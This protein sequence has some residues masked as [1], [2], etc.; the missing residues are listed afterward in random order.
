MNIKKIVSA[1]KDSNLENAD[2]LITGIETL[3]H[4]LNNENKT[5]REAKEST[6]GK[7]KEFSGVDSDSLEDILST[8][9]NKQ[10]GE[11]SLSRK[12]EKLEAALA[13]IEQEKTALE[14]SNHEKTRNENIMKTLS[15]QGVRK[16]AIEGLTQMFGSM[17]KLDDDGEWLIGD[18][19]LETGIS[20]YVAK[21][22][23]FVDSQQKAGS[24]TSEPKGNGK[25]T[26][27][28]S[29][30]VLEMTSKER[31]DNM[32]VIRESRAQAAEAGKEW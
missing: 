4:T 30:D 5:L 10:N 27:L 15:K 6:V 12:V 11:K 26:Y 17:S 31:M 14:R 20:E 7:I 13:K 8:L 3:Y 18:G 23:Y 24:G 28:S 25:K 21:N 16:D 29:Q 19:D 22:Q 9:Q 32:S 1:L 2:E